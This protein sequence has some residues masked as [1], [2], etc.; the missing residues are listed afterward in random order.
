VSKIQVGD[1]VVV[2]STHG[3]Y[4]ET[5]GEVSAVTRDGSFVLVKRPGW[6]FGFKQDWFREDLLRVV[7]DPPSYVEIPQKTN[8]PTFP[9]A[10]TTDY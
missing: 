9:R 8:N 2:T 6:L 5:E 4:V 10:R 7:E 3:G 1:R